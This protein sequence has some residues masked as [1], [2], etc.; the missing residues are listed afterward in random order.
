MRG[1]NTPN[2]FIYRDAACC[3]IIISLC[4]ALLA[5]VYLIIANWMH[6]DNR[7]RQWKMVLLDSRS[8]IVISLIDYFILLVV[9]LCVLRLLAVA[10]SRSHRAYPAKQKELRSLRPSMQPNRAR[11]VVA[12][13]FDLLKRFRLAFMCFDYGEQI[14]HTSTKANYVWFWTMFTIGTT[15]YYCISR[16]RRSVRDA[17]D[18]SSLTFQNSQ[19]EKCSV[20]YLRSAPKV[21]LMLRSAAT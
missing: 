11:R 19:L 15:M 17:D 1:K 21:R 14:A 20:F 6:D 5:R 16:H 3:I 4:V 12:N 7:H 10:V 2:C 8:T 18:K 9:Y 13:Q